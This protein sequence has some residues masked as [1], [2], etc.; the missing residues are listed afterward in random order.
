MS[1][2]ITIDDDDNDED[3]HTFDSVPFV[4][5]IGGHLKIS[6]ISSKD[7]EITSKDQSDT[8]KSLYYQHEITKRVCILCLERDK[9]KESKESM[10]NCSYSDQVGSDG[11]LKF[12]NF[13]KHIKAKHRR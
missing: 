2:T 1:N 11:K 10:K 3:F 8:Y 7:P 6:R 13:M 9:S 5:N 12:S 4:S